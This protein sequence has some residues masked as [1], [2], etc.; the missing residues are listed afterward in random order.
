[1]TEMVRVLAD[2]LEP[3]QVG[4]RASTGHSLGW[5]FASSTIKTCGS[6]TVLAE[7]STDRKLTP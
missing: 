5:K 4:T 1:M 2:S 7:M 3:R 6:R